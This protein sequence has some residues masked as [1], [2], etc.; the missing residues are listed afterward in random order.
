VKAG[1]T[2][3]GREDD[4][5]GIRPL[6]LQWVEKTQEWEAAAEGYHLG[7]FATIAEANAA[8]RAF[9]GRKHVTEVFVNGEPFCRCIVDGKFVPAVVPVQ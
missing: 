9:S 3:P 6:R 8:Y 7:H 1:I 4:D 2:L 5:D